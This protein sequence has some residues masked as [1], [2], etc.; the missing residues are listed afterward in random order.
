MCPLYVLWLPRNTKLDLALIKINLIIV[1]D[2]TNIMFVEDNTMKLPGLQ[3]FK[4]CSKTREF[5]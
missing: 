1:S 2:A 3:L 5:I 4:G